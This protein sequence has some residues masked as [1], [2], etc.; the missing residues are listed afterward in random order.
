[1]KPAGAEF[2][3]HPVLVELERRVQTKLS[4]DATGHDQ[5]HVSRVR[6]LAVILANEEGADQLVV[7]AAALLHDLYRPEESREGL[8]HYG[9][10]ALAGMRTLLLEVEFPPEKIDAVLHCVEVHE[11]YGFSGDQTRASLEAFILRDADRLDAVGAIG[12][13]RVFMFSGAH[14][15]SLW[16]PDERP[17]HWSANQRPGG[18]AITH[19]YEKLLRLEEEMHT[20]TARRCARRRHEFMERFLEE[21]FAEWRGDDCDGKG[22]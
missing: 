22:G 1:M 4:A 15:R 16:E 20:Q 8:L 6:R 7:E 18:S 14:G 10:E 5:W 9:P 19:F 2:E 11:N 21:F 13:A 3:M 12:I 17:K